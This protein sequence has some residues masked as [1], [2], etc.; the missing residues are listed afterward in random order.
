MPGQARSH[1][2][3]SATASDGA[4]TTAY[5]AS[6]PLVCAQCTGAILPDQVFSRRSPHVTSAAMGGVTTAPVCVTCRPLRIDGTADAPVP[7]DEETL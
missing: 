6:V 1:V 4:R 7:T 2:V 5:R 3:G